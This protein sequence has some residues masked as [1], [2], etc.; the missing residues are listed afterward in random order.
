MYV[1][2]VYVLFMLMLGYY[3]INDSC[4]VRSQVELELVRS[5]FKNYFS[6]VYTL[7]DWG[8]LMTGL[9][10]SNADIFYYEVNGSN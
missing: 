10:F 2:Y 3:P 1:G 4:S 7:L 6:V 5:L 9:V 8:R